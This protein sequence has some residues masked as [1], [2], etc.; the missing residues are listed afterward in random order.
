M[1]LNKR[2]IVGAHITIA[3]DSAMN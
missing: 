2:R 1:I 3:I